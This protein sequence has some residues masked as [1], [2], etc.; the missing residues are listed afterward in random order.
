MVPITK[1]SDEEFDYIIHLS[2]LHI[3]PT[4]RHIEYEQVFVKLYQSIQQLKNEGCRA[5][6]VITGD[7]FDNKNRFSPAQYNLCNQFF[8]H[9]CDLYPLIVI[10]GNHDMKDSTTI[11]S[12]TP[13]AYKRDNFYYLLESGAYEYGSVVFVVSSL[14]HPDNYLIKRSEVV[15]NKRCLAL[16]HGTISGSRN[17][18]DSEKTNI[19]TNIDIYYV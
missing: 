9:L 11:D 6:I 14:Y 7:V 5:V 13:S 12:I 16:Y 10:L 2:D 15:T 1:I 3:R 18:E 8:D 17:D 4:E 19:V